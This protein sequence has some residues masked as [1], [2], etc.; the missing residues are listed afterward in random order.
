MGTPRCIAGRSFPR[1]RGAKAGDGG[2]APL[3][4]LGIATPAALDVVLPEL[5]RERRAEN[6]VL[7]ANDEVEEVPEERAVLHGG[8]QAGMSRYDGRPV[9]DHSPNFLSHRFQSVSDQS[10]QSFGSLQAAS[11]KDVLLVDRPPPP[12]LIGTCHQQIGDD[13]TLGHLQRSCRHVS[14]V[15]HVGIPFSRHAR[16]Y[17]RAKDASGI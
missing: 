4:H 3:G 16:S 11:L 10:Q 9:A 15:P 14:P 2:L 8:R 6:L 5:V 1:G 13:A 17:V 12:G 7:L